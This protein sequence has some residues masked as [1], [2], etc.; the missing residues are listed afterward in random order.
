M[1]NR[2]S[3]RLLFIINPASG[4]KK[5]N[6]ELEINNYMANHQYN[7]EC[8]V[9]PLQCPADLIKKRIEQTKPD[10]V[11]ATGGDGTIKL[12]AECL[13]KT[14][15]PL[16][17]IPAGSANGMAK[18][19]AI[20]LNL[21]GALDII[22]NG[23]TT[24]V[25]MIKVNDELCIHLSDIGFNAFVVKK[26]EAGTGRGMWGYIKASWQVLRSHAKMHAKI[27]VNKVLIERYASMIVIANATRYGS[28]A[29]INPVGTLDDKVFEV[30]VVKKISMMEIFKMMV[31]HSNYNP[32]KTELFQTDTLQINSKRKAHFQVD[33]EYR[34]KINHLEASIIPNAVQVIVAK[35]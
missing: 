28:G 17:I 26:F 3:L 6:Y 16:G 15:I 31:T 20:P 19:L 23:H 4:N 35:P 5:V 8:F 9:M 24:P 32:Q 30:I 18:E 12:V 33:G 21:N 27:I 29:L 13:M 7:V 22:I 11:I 34:G 25:S 1:N 2:T 14:Q 10:R